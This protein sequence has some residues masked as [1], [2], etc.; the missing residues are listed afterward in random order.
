[1]NPIRV[2]IVLALL[3]IGLGTYI[4]FVDIPKTRQLKKQETQ[5]RQ[6]L[7][8]D[9]RTVTHMISGDGESRNRYSPQPTTEKFEQSYEP[10]RL[11]KSNALSQRDRTRWPHTA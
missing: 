2:T 5:E 11:E 8:F 3:V 10:L 9:D 4:L 1:M 6:L 7:P